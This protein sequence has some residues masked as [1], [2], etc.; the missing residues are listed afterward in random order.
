MSFRK[1][2]FVRQEA[3]RVAIGSPVEDVAFIAGDIQ[4]AADDDR[5]TAPA[6]RGHPRL[7]FF[8]PRVLAGLGFIAG[9]A[10]GQVDAD[11][12]D[13][14]DVD[15]KHAALRVGIA[16]NAWCAAG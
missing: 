7:E 11:E 2:R 13:A 4:V 10:A 15:S 14:I 3:A 1:V 16:V 12:V 9:R 5:T 6:K 8:H